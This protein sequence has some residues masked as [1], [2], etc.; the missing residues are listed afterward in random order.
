[1]TVRK[2]FTILALSS[3]FAANAA[4][5]SRTSSAAVGAKEADVVHRVRRETP[6]VIGRSVSIHH[7][8]RLHHIKVKPIEP[9]EHA[10]P[11]DASE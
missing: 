9:T 6:I 10:T 11:A 5:A 8:T 2:T 7:K 3:L 4:L 1:M